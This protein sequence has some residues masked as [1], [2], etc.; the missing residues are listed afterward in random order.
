MSK[1]QIINQLLQAINASKIVSGMS[2]STANELT[3][4]VRQLEV[5]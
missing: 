1:E 4:L 3:C 5:A 2:W